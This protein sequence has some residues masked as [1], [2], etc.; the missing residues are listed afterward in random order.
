MT[1]VGPRPTG[2]TRAVSLER[3]LFAWDQTRSMPVFF[4][5]PGSD[6]DYIAC[7]D[8]AEKLRAFHARARVDFDS[9]KQIENGREF[10][11]SV[12]ASP[13]TAIIVDPWFALDGRVRFTQVFP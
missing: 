13:R 3:K 1:G 11:A 8:S 5:T 12:A 2:K 7:F 9:I 4:G 6:L 10:I